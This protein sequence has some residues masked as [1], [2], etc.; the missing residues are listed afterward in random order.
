MKGRFH[1]YEG[2]QA[3]KVGFPIRVMKLL[4]VT[5]V[6]VT[7]AAGGMNTNFTVGDFMILNGK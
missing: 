3:W 7:N 4:G 6:I 1:P 5:G 2:Y